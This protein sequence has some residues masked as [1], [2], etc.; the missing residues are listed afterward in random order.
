MKIA[1]Y[2]LG[3]KLNQAETDEL[4]ESLQNEGFF[5]VGWK[6]KAD[7]YV[8]NACGLTAGAEQGTRQIIRQAK[9]RNHEAKIFVTGCFGQK[10]SEV[11]YYSKNLSDILKKIKMAHSTNKKA[12]GLPRFLLENRTRA[13]IKIQ[14][15]CDNFCSYCIIPY[16][17]GKPKSV[18]AQ[19]I[20]A[21]VKRKVNEGYKEIVLTGVNI[22]KYH[23][24]GTNL[25]RLIHKILRE[26][27]IQRI[28]LGSLDPSLIN[29]NFISLFHDPR[30]MPHLHLSLQ[31]GS[32]RVL[33]LMNRKYTA[34]QYLSLA[35]KIKNKFPLVG[36][37]TDIIVGFPGETEKDFRDTYLLA[38]KVGFFKIHI[39]PYSR[40]PNTAAARMPDQINEKIKENRFFRLQKI[41]DITRKKFIKKMIGQTVPVLF[42]ERK[43]NF[44]FGHAPNYLRIKSPE[45][46][47]LN[48]KIISIKINTNNID[49][50]TT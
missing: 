14:T 43:N 19:K 3:C 23:F 7:I 48:N 32:N 33:K 1:V 15:G 36:F 41:A 13:F 9:R 44:W 46:K 17:R 12:N 50:L 24:H 28:R 29:D 38:K 16:F 2:T 10:I 27:S 18:N 42:E 39:F 11:D 35:K 45:T 22:C 37:T 49:L 6:N 26:T 47:N 20:I 5:I 25:D 21:A 30:I 4:K 8:V 40:R 31:S 34:R